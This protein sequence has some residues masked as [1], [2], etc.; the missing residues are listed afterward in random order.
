M[1]GIVAF[2]F[3]VPDSIW[4]NRAIAQIAS[5]KARDLGAPI[6]TQLDVPIPYW[7]AADRANEE[8]G[9]PPPTLRIAREAV[10]W[11]KLRSIEELWVVAAGPHLWRV[12]RDLKYAIHEAETEAQI[13]VQIC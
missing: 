5:I 7:V 9:N 1:K 10:L 2:A 3:G 13:K 12:V 6:F 11:A 4:S 8:A